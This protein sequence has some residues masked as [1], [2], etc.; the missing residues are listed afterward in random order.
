M[1]LF[2][3]TLIKAAYIRKFRFD[4]F[5]RFGYIF[6][7][8]NLK[9]DRSDRCLNRYRMLA[10]YIFVFIENTSFSLIWFFLRTT[11]AVNDDTTFMAVALVVL[12]MVSFF[13]GIAFLLIYYIVL[14]P[15]ISKKPFCRSSSSPSEETVHH[16]NATKTSNPD[17]V[18]DA[19]DSE[20][21]N[22]RPPPDIISINKS[23]EDVRSDVNN[24]QQQR[25]SL[26]SPS[27]A[28]SPSLRKSRG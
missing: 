5:Y 6:T 27:P 23:Y 28:R 21:A 1:H 19:I 25:M 9:E 26:L 20:R 14:H 2:G 4:L 16:P 18:I 3:L 22:C 11:N 7:Y 24:Q 13:V 10:Y 8:M 17:V 12:V 15:T